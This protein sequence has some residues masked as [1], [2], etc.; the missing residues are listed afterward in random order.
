VLSD[1][2]GPRP[3][4]AA[5]ED[6]QALRSETGHEVE[7][8]GLSP[9]ATSHTNGK[10]VERVAFLILLG[11]VFAGT[12]NW[13]G[14][15][16]LSIQFSDEDRRAI[17]ELTALRDVEVGEE[18]PMTDVA[19]SRWIMD[20]GFEPPEEDGTWISSREAR[21][22]FSSVDGGALSTLSLGFFPFVTD[23][24]PSRRLTI[25]TSLGET[26]LLLTG[27]GQ[28]TTV[29]LDGE[30]SQVV[31]INCE[32]VDAPADLGISPDVRTLCAKLLWIR[33]GR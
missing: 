19:S 27:G 9:I 1:F 32:S 4:R 18:L 10:W 30:S 29:P 14:N 5:V 22:V 20:R 33:L 23:Q 12:W 16:D 28:A 6:D 2:N 26:A 21:I 31:E 3:E 11:L 25:K 24:V 17:D 8:V 15:T 7:V 13:V